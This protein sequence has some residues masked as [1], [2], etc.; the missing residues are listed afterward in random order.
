MVARGERRRDDD[1][2]ALGVGGR[3]GHSLAAVTQFN[4]LVRRR[5]AGDDRLAGRIDV[6]HVEG[7]PEG[8]GLGRGLVGRSRSFCRGSRCRRRDNRRFRLDRS[9]G[10]KRNI[11]R[12]RLK[13]IRISPDDGACA[14]GH[15]HKGGCSDPNQRVPRR[16]SA[17]FSPQH[18]LPSGDCDKSL[19]PRWRLILANP[20]RIRVTTTRPAFPPAPHWR[21]GRW[22]GS[23]GAAPSSA[24]K[25]RGRRPCR[26]A[27]SPQATVWRFRAAVRDDRPGSPRRYTVACLTAK[28]LDARRGIDG[29]AEKNDLPLHRS[30]LAGHHRA[31]MKSGPYCN[32]R[33]EFA[34][35]VGRAF[36]KLV[37]SGETGRDAPAVTTPS[38][39]VHVAI[40]SSPIYRWI[41]PRAATIGSVR[42]RTKRLRRR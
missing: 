8:R 35:I 42:S 22:S 19:T 41:S 33:A 9:P 38:S 25:A 16:H 31:A 15:D 10:R 5:P 36:R 11:S 4:L 2:L 37:D 7:G 6:H 40:S 1:E 26:A 23:L 12:I 21:L 27:S 3:L 17:R 32:G 20:L 30:H 29:V 13:K 18:I 24:H 39:S 34:A 14:C 28:V